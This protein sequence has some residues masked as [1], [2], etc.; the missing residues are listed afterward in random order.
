[1]STRAYKAED[2]KELGLY[3][4][5]KRKQLGL[6]MDQVQAMTKIAK[7]TIVN[8]E[9]GRGGQIASLFK[10]CRLVGVNIHVNG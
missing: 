3:I 1:M 10:L 5:R 6:T 2:A 9:K 8:I 7:T 4:A